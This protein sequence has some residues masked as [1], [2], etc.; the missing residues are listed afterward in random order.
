MKGLKTLMVELNALNIWKVSGPVAILIQSDT[1][2]KTCATQTLS[3][4][5]QGQQEM[6]LTQLEGL[7]FLMYIKIASL[8]YTTMSATDGQLK[9]NYSYIS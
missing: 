9:V 2:L 1:N 6:I 7:Q 5:E 3:D 4:I 8:E